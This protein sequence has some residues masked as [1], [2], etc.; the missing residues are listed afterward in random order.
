MALRDRLR[1]LEKNAQGKLSSFE[2][3]DGSRYFYEPEKVFPELFGHGARCLTADYKGEP[4][5]EPP[6][7]L[8]AIVRARDR[9]RVAER[10]YT[11]FTAYDLDAL[12]ERG[13]FTP[14]SYLANHSYEESVEYYARKNRE[15]EG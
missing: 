14:R 5:P 12:V 4:R 15:Q 13:E 3:A 10:L 7:I 6:E 1:R 8:K 2:L 9:R 11:P